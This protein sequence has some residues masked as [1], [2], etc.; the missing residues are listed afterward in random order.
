MGIFNKFK[1]GGVMDTIKC[2]EKDDFL[3]WKW[4]P[5]RDL[6][7]GESRKE[8]SI[9]SGSTLYVKPGQAAVFLYPKGGCDVIIGPYNDRITTDNMP[10]LASLVG[11]MFAGGTPFPAEVYFVNQQTDLDIPFFVEGIR[12]N[13]PAQQTFGDYNM[14]YFDLRV[15]VKGRLTFEV[16]RTKEAILN[17]LTVNGSIDTPME[18]VEEKVRRVLPES[19]GEIV[20]M[21]P[22]GM[23][24][25]LLALETRKREVGRYVLGML[26]DPQ[27]ADNLEHRFG[28]NLLGVNITEVI[29]DS[30][31]DTY[32]MLKDYAAQDHQANLEKRARVNAT[33]I[34]DQESVLNTRRLTLEQQENAI[35]G[36]QK[37]REMLGTDVDV[38]NATT[39]MTAGIQ[40]EHMQ[41]QLAR[42]REE[43]QYAQH[44][45][46]DEA[47]RQARLGTESAFINAHALNQ[48]A[49]VM[50]TGL[51][52]M[53]Q[54]GSMNLGGGEGHMNPAGMMTGMMMGTAVAGQMGQMM[55]QMGGMMQQN[56]AGAGQP[57]QAPPPLPNQQATAYYLYING[58][59]TGPASAQ[60]IAQM[61]GAGQVTG[62]TLAWCEGMAQW[63]PAKDI[64]GL[65]S[66]FT[67]PA[68]SVPPPVPPVPPAPPVPPV[69]PV[70][71]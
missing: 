65:Q 4:R 47:A 11:T 57:Q 28:L 14:E 61:A 7:P 71:P 13:P 18:E 64:P 41:D 3:I 51:Q 40:M 38:R 68:S 25:G 27:A 5:N 55:N 48:Q 22:T 9:R 8:T 45:Q 6:G 16:P 29:Y 10:V 70:N 53:G 24:I 60:A 66:I 37:Q 63:S 26:K 44:S 17:V 54:M 50:K 21:A 34:M 15:N 69:P 32:Q 52:N 23:G 42:M 12:L 58:N 30:E 56:M 43:G 59:Q 35:F 62:D 2:E 33:G 49:D 46:T 67:P 20:S 31:S 19:V 1:E 36:V 39:R